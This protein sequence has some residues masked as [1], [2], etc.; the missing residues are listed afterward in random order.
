MEWQFRNSQRYP[1]YEFDARAQY[2]HST[3]NTGNSGSSI[4]R[5]WHRWWY[6]G[7][8]LR[9]PVTLE[10]SVWR[11]FVFSTRYRWYSH[12]INCDI[13][14]YIYNICI[15][16]SLS[17]LYNFLTA[18]LQFFL[19]TES[20]GSSIRQLWLRWVVIMTTCGVI[21]DCRFCRTDNLLFS[22]L[23]VPVLSVL[24]MF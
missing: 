6:H 7:L 18:L 23:D 12:L 14:I 21:I 22:M 11:S 9:Q 4:K 16:V 24:L 13:Y 2:K 3:G 15:F 8:S 19:F 10:L 1:R 20:K 5:H 17:C